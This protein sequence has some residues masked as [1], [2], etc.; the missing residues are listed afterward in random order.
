MVSRPRRRK[1]ALTSN[2]R[3]IPF[4]EYIHIGIWIVLLVE[5]Q[6]SRNGLGHIGEKSLNGIF[7]TT[8]D[9]D[10]KKERRDRS[11]LSSTC[12]GFRLGIL[13]RTKR[14]WCVASSCIVVLLRVALVEKIDMYVLWPF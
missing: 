8:G 10:T 9:G 14:E 2:D 4:E 3:K 1:A 5:E 6:L 11:R 7:R 13:V 12:P